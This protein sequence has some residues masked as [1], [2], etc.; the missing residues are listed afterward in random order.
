MN[1]KETLDWLFYQLP[2][3]QHKGKAAYKANLDNTIAL[4][5]YFDSPHKNFK[6]IHIAGTNGKGSV[7]HMLASVL[8]EAGYKVG[9]YTS[10]HLKSFRERIRINGEMIPEKEVV[11][12]VDNH[13]KI[14]NKIKS[15]FFEMTVA[16][17]FD[18]FN[19]NNIDIAVVEV[20]LGGRLDSTN[21]ITP[22]LSVI[23][24]ISLEHTAFLGNTIDKI[25]LEKAGIIKNNIP[26]V[27]GETQKNIKEIF[28]NKALKENSSIAFADKKYKIEYSF[29]TIDNHQIF[30]V[31]SD[32]IIV[33]KN[34]K[35][36]LL[37]WYQ[38]KNLITVLKTIDILKEKGFNILEKHIFQGISKTKENTNLLGRWQILQYNPTIVCDTGHNTD[39]IKEVMKQ[40]KETPH[41]NLHIVIGVVNDKNIDKI[42]ELLPKK[43]EYYFTKANIPRALNQKILAEKAKK[44]K[45]QGKTYKNVAE[46]I[47]NAKKNSSSNDLIFIGGS[48]FVVADGF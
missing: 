20:G 23:T 3:Y 42:L 40:I 31:Y 38:K 11:N 26:V 33:Y 27:I 22:E 29:N 46:A 13:S 2:M 25:A 39:G 21:I 41:E 4:D 8:Q 17:A 7:S 5:N 44:K 1:Y 9:L 15:S 37:G 18:Y 47:K 12:F 6:C 36:D 35:L 16:M 48:T 19:K 32:N 45:L 34:L 14:F 43:A 10:P 28:K 30:N 24:N